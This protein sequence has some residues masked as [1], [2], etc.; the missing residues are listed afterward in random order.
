MILDTSFVID[1]LRGK[2]KAILKMQSLIDK[3]ISY[4]IASPTIFELW[5]GLVA[6]ENS[7]KDLQKIISLI[8][9]LTIY[10]LDEESAKIA[11]KI[12]GK[13]AKEGLKIDTEDSMIAG[14]AISNN[15]KILTRDEHFSRIKE[16]KIEEY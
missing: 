5:G 8:E 10:P 13:L 11:G 12:D 3:N 1:F 14:I 9:S 6:L 15:R 16:L 4:E 7:E 2:E